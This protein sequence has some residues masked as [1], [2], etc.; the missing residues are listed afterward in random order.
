MNSRLLIKSLTPMKKCVPKLS[1]YE[2]L[3]VIS[4]EASCYLRTSSLNS[5]TLA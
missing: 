4:E 1:D 3:K 2:S 5:Y